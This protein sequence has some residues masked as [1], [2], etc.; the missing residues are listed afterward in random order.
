MTRVLVV[1]EAIVDVIDGSSHPGGSPVNV[2]IG[3][4]RL[5]ADVTLCT[6]IGNDA[7]GR[8]LIRHVERAG[9]RLAPGSLTSG[10]TSTAKIN[11]GTNGVPQYEFD[12]TWDIESIPTTGADILH[13]GSIGAFLEPGATAVLAALGR[14]APGTLV[15]FD[16]NIRPALLASRTEAVSRME[17]I[18]A[19]SHVIKLS[20]EDAAWLY[21]NVAAIAVLRRLAGLGPH[22]VVM[23][24][25]SRGALALVGPVV[26]DLPA[27]RVTVAD[28]VGAGDAFMSGLLAALTCAEMRSV[29]AIGAVPLEKW[30]DVF[31]VALQ[32]AAITVSRPGANPPSSEE[33]TMPSSA[34]SAN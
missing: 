34:D 7:N 6:R 29:A 20:D 4:A 14:A 16:P 12:V 8:L 21:P 17:M 13:V 9:V 32:S 23:T 19:K 33:L 22:A 11:V 25:G 15:S 24:R 27:A 30:K 28:T 26:V 3:M 1:G 10:R 18:A 2:A 5:G 31:Q